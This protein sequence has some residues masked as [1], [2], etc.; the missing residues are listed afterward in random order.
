[1]KVTQVAD[2]TNA[3]L[4]SAIGETAILAQDLSNVIDVGRVLFAAG[5][6]AV[7]NFVRAL[8]DHIGKMLFV[9]R[10]YEGIVPSILRDAWEYGSICEK[11]RSEIPEAIDNPAWELVDGETYNQDKFY[12]PKVHVKFWNDRD[13]FMIPMV[14]QR[15]RSRV[16]Q[17]NP[18]RPMTIAP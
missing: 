7:D 8:P 10:E 3:A 1:M 15:P 18:S 6:G 13:T 12:A 17:N 4:A 16:R 2:W 5:D 11:I 14:K 9:D